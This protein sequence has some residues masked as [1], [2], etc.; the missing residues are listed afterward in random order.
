MVRA[1][2]GGMFVLKRMADARRDGDQVLAV[3][4]GS[5]VN[6]DGRSN[7]LPAPN[8]E[9]QVRAARRLHRCGAPIRATSTTSGAHGT[10]DPR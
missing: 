8:P 3:I 7:G 10:G 9:A 6:S 5:A 4:A 1:E 2:G